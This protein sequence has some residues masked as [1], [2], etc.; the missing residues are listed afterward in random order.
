VVPGVN[1]KGINTGVFTG[2]VRLAFTGGPVSISRADIAVLREGAHPLA[3]QDPLANCPRDPA[4]CDGLYGRYAEMDLAQ[5]L[6]EGLAPGSSGGDQE[7]IQEEA[8][9]PEDRRFSVRAALGD[10]TPGFNHEYLNFAITDEKLGPSSQPNA[11]LAV[12]VTYYDDPDLTGKVFRPEVFIREN[13]NGSTGFAFLPASQGTTLLGS[14][15][16]MDSYVEIP[17][18]KFNGV[19]QGPQAAARF[20]V[21]GKVAISRVRYAVI[22]TCGAAAGTN[23]L[24][25]AKP[26]LQATRTPEGALRLSWVAGQNWRLQSSETLAPDSWQDV[27]EAPSVVDFENV[28]DLP[29]TEPPNR[30][31]RIAK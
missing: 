24:E 2:A 20:A 14:G 22:P 27:P 1:L 7:M 3:G 12:V 19:N 9:P 5:G 23:S 29:I 15:R 16:W 8:G 6:F 28:V 30:F 18:I 21:T 13:P 25:S 11:R 10:G 4:V 31:Y 26:P 17:D